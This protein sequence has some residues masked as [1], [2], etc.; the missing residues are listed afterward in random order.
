M[1]L[2]FDDVT[3]NDIKDC[4]K[5]FETMPPE[6]VSDDVFTA[7]FPTK[8]DPLH[9]TPHPSTPP[10]TPNKSVPQPPASVPSPTRSF[11]L[12][13][14]PASDLFEHSSNYLFSESSP[15]S[16]KCPSPPGSPQNVQLCPKL[17][18]I[19]RS[20]KTEAPIK[21]PKTKK[22]VPR[23]KKLVINRHLPYNHEKSGFL[24]S[25]LFNLFN[26]LETVVGEINQK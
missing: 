20:L 10:H 24:I 17:N 9:S 21:E 14:N 15:S 1:S 2:Q 4:W 7:Q 8:L 25:K 23:C 16:P 11:L 18:M 6:T 13:L 19:F 5:L 22:K 26:T 12:P 3:S